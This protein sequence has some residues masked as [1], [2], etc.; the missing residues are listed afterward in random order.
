LVAGSD[1]FVSYAHADRERVLVLRDALTAAGLGVWL[2]EGQIDT[3]ASI[4]AAIEDGLAHSRL[5]LAFYSRAYAGRRACQWELTAALLAAQRAGRDLRERVLV[6]NPEPDARHVEPVELRDALHA[7]AP[8]SDD[9]DG[10]QAVAARVA[11]HARGLSGEL[12]GLGVGVR[13]SWHGRAAVGSARFVGRTRDMWTVHSALSAGAVGLISAQSTADPAV[14]VAGMGGIGKSLLAQE[15]ALRYAAVYPGGVFW[16]RAHGHDARAGTLQTRQARDADRDT[17]LLAFAADLGL[18]S[19]L[20]PGQVRGALARELDARGEAFLWVVDDLPPDL[21]TDALEGW[22]APGSLGRSLLTTRSRQYRAVGAQLD[23]GVLTAAEGVELLERHRKLDG[24]AER[25]VARGLVADLGGHALALDVAGAALA[26][27]AGARSI[28]RYRAA[29]SD[30]GADELELAA[31]LADELPGGHEASIAS[32]LMRSIAQLDKAGLDFL[33]VAAQ[34]AAEPIA[35]GLLTDTF[36]LADSLDESTARRRAVTGMHGA[37]TRSLADTAGPDERHVHAL[38]ARTIRLRERE[39]ARASALG[40]AAI[41]TLTT[42]LGELAPGRVSADGVLLA[43]ARH[44]AAPLHTSQHALLLHE[45]AVHDSYRGDYPGARAQQQR[46][47]DTFRRLLG[48]EHPATLSSMNNL[49]DTLR[50]LGD[51]GGARTLHEQTLTTCRR[52]LGDEHPATLSSMSNLALTLRGLGDLGGARTLFEQT[53]TTCRRV[54]GDE[55]PDTLTSMSN[56]A[57][58]LR[59]LGDLG[60]ARTLHEQTLTTCRRVLG[61]EHPATLS[62]MSNLAVTLRGLGDLGGARTLFEQTLTIRRRV[63]GD[64]HAATLTSMSNLADT[65]G[66]LGDLGGA[67]TLHEQTL[68]IRRRVLGDEHPDTLQSMNNLAATLDALGDLGGARTLHEQTLT[69]RRRV[70]GDEHPATLTSMSNLAATLDALGDLGGARTLHEQT[71]TI[72][73]RVLGDEHPDTLQSMNNLAATLGGL[74]DLGGART[75][76]EQTLTIRRR[77]LGDEHPDTL[78]SMSNLAA[79][80][81]ALGDLGGARTLHEQTLTIRRRVLGDEHPDTLNPQRALTQILDELGED[82]SARTPPSTRTTKP[83][84]RRLP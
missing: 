29:L 61:D 20:Q 60:G 38:I 48:D 80:L 36:A 69:I 23:L 55:H 7:A 63:L 79:T 16:L 76:H 84:R 5:L 19:D 22:L 30:R 33:R 68:T 21:D 78:Q 83:T 72:R 4:T 49:A 47:L 24:P 67:R 58:T 54:L 32:T 75:L 71:L 65:L 37:L 53:L 39:P 42:R 82:S 59:G 12:G 8:A 15:Y 46:V 26:A 3:F 17:Q 77:V 11:A 56:L 2:D 73:R 34:L 44:L 45:V 57:D 74:R 10:W 18:D 1:V 70:L 64:E 35:S 9:R 51:L 43:H 25:A 50:R 81:D 13:P 52:V 62:S 6:V 14:K 28:E 41:R 66:G 27:E 31:K 40:D